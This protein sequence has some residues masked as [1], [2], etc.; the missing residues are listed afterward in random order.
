MTVIFFYLS[1]KRLYYSY[2][3]LLNAVNYFTMVHILPLAVKNWQQ[4]HIQTAN[5]FAVIT[6]LTISLPA[7]DMRNKGKGQ[8]K[9]HLL[10][11]K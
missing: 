9:K 5:E 6:A 8:E 4:H 7:F 10:H 2:Q 3:Q 11:W 1:A